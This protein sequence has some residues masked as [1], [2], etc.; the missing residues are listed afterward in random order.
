MASSVGSTLP[1][2][3]YIAAA[4]AVVVVLAMRVTHYVRLATDYSKDLD[5]LLCRVL[6]CRAHNTIRWT[7][8]RCTSWESALLESK[9][10]GNVAVAF[11]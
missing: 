11:P 4:V 5:D 6:A 10:A 3:A 9:H 1:S 8:L 2:P 7:P